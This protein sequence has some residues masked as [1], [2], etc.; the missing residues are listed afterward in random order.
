MFSLQTARLPAFCTHQLLREASS[1]RVP[2]GNACFAWNSKDGSLGGYFP[3][4]L[5]L[6]A[7]VP[8]TSLNWFWAAEAGGK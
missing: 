3:F 8:C 7:L 6:T 2:F 4:F 5:L 1:G